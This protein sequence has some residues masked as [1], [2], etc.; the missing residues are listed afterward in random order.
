VYFEKV[1]TTKVYL[2]DCTSISPYPLLLFG[3]KLDVQ[4]AESVITVDAW[5]GLKG[6]RKVA[7]LFKMLRYQLDMLLRTKVEVCRWQWN[8]TVFRLKVLKCHAAEP[9]G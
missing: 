8:G 3:G 5:I 4:H 6:P 1:K 9:G 7:V 2:R